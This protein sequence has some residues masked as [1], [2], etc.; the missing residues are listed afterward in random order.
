MAV[1]DRWH[2]SPAADGEPCRCGND[3]CTCGRQPC[4]CGRGRNRLYASAD[5]L[6]GSRWQVRWDSPNSPARK[7]PSRNFAL[8]EGDDANKHAD[9]FDKLIQAQILTRSYVDPKSQEI[10]F[11]QYAEQLRK[12]RR[13]TDPY[14]AADLERR[15]RLH[16]YEDERKPG[17]GLTPKGTPAIGHQALGVLAQRVSLVSGW[18]DGIALG[19]RRKRRVMGDVS[20]VFRM[21]MADGIVGRDPVHAETVARP[22]APKRLARA[23]SP[24]QCGAIRGELPG[25]YRVLVDLG[26]GTG[27]RQSEMLGLGADDVDWLAR[28]KDDPQVHVRRQLKW[29]ERKPYFAPVKNRKPHSAPLATELKEALGAHLKEFPALTVTLPWWE[30]EDAQPGGR[31][32]KEVTVR[33]VISNASRRPVYQYSLAKTWRAAGRR[34]KV[35]PEDAREREDGCHALRHTFASNCLRAGIDPVRVAEWMGDTVKTVVDFYAHFMPGRSNADAR[36][37]IGAFLRPE[38]G[39]RNVR[40]AAGSAG[41]SR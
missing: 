23:W 1:H 19:A 22:E 21:A 9:A 2:K 20:R 14:Q 38:P 37:A 11:R 6:K 36:R 10:T 25:R 29:I 26:S 31:H 16:A 15:L 34:A 24:E 12:G 13:I 33:L 32:L 4:K 3:P 28:E 7:Q 8:K 27:M 41:N 18:A 5:H 35:T 30:P 40:G 39:A 17:S